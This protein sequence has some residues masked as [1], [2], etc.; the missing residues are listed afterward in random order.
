MC[1][2]YLNQLGWKTSS[3]ISLA[4]LSIFV[5]SACQWIPLEDF[6]EHKALTVAQNVVQ[7]TKRRSSTKGFPSIIFSQREGGRVLTA[8]TAVLEDMFMYS[9]GFRPT[10]RKVSKN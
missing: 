9:F 2:I 10:L 5:S 1:C 6:R 7:P 8:T 4:N 3:F